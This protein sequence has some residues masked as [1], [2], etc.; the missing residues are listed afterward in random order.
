MKLEEALQLYEDEYLEADILALSPKDRLYWYTNAK[1][2]QKP[3]R[4][5]TSIDPNDNQL[6]DDI[7]PDKSL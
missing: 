1:E 4:Q 6:P 5:R 7:Y 3:K 2:F